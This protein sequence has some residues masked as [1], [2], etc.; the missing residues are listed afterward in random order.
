M[1]KST[2]ERSG[3]PF[4]RFWTT[5][6]GVWFLRDFQSRKSH[7]KINKTAGEDDQE[8]PCTIFEGGVGGRGGARWGFGVWKFWDL[9]EPDSDSS[10]PFQ[11][12]QRQG[13]ADLNAPCGA[14][15]A[16][17]SSCRSAFW[18]VRLLRLMAFCKTANCRIAISLQRFLRI[19]GS[20]WSFVVG[21]RRSAICKFIF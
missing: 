8:E 13:A 14:S 9:Q 12:C 4:L 21:A 5:S 17:P 6:W 16:A 1:S 11:P 20:S 3:A 18:C 19:F 2:L 10:T 15:T 7:P